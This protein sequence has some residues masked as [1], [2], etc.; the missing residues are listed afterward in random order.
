MVSIVKVEVS[1]DLKNAKIFLSFYDDKKTNSSSEY[2]NFLK[3]SLGQIKFKIGIALKTKYVP[4]IKFFLSD[5][6]EY[7]DKISRILKND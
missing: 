7:Y 3:K 5:E 2:F 1:P 4:N 6:Y